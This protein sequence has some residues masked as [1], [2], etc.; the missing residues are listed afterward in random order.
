MNKIDI[1]L[2]EMPNKNYEKFFNK[3]KEIDTLEVSSW[4]GTHLLGYF[5]KKYKEQYQ[6]DYQ[7]K[8]NSPA[9]SKCFE[10]FQIKKLSMRLTSDPVL[11]KE[12]IDWLFLNKVNQ[13]KRRLTSISFINN[14]ETVNAY[15]FNVL[16][17][18]DDNQII[19]RTTPLPEKYKS[20]FFGSKWS[21][22]TYGEL[23][24][25]YQACDALSPE[26]VECF[27]KLE[28][29]GFDKKILEKIV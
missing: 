4:N 14:E 7:F 13:A 25:A 15:K 23:S 5:C 29:I 24:F 2:G 11:L 16:M 22:Q 3:F 10:V 28:K 18:K 26:L 12:Y 1:K 19:N 27:M 20:V 9:P 17:K 6:I 21:M 8:F